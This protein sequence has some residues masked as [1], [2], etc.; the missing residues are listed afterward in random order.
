MGPVKKTKFS[1]AQNQNKHLKDGG[2]HLTVRRPPVN[3]GG[4]QLE[5][6]MI[7]QIRSLA[8]TALTTN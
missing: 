4:P 2:R 6:H 1:S 3:C 7:A 8:G 5:G